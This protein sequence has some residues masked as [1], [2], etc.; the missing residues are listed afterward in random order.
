MTGFI[1]WLGVAAISI[2][3]ASVHA[4][5]WP[6]KPVRFIVPWPAGGL[7]DLIARVYN[8]EVSK[9]IRQPVVVDFKAG[10]GGRIGIT[11]LARAAPD[12]Y[13]I[14]MGNLGPLT[15]YPH[16]YKTLPYDVRKDLVPVTMFAV[17]PQ[18]L[19]VTNKLPAKDV[20][21]LVALAKKEPGKL[22]YASVGIGS[23]QHLALQLVLTKAGAQ[24]VHVPY[25]GTSESLPNLIAGEVHAMIDTLPVL[26][27]QIRAGKIRALAVTTPQRVPQLPDVPTLTEAGY[28]EVDAVSWYA[29]MVPTG[30][31]EAIIS[32][33]YAEYTAA[34]Q[35]PAVKKFLL[36]QGLIYL[37][38]TREQF[39]ARIQAESE[40]WGRIVQ[41]QK[42]S[43]D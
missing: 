4:Q 26:L 24:M 40:R 15:I 32:R 33:L 42:I 25:K 7:N 30:T 6:A 2:L 37:P 8:D 9:A 18:V 43:L 19:V 20:G 35:T 31:P 11:E 3:A 10:A 27:T 5:D 21:E 39:A 16:L 13:T 23:L 17:S 36:E 41:D 12:G 1:R 29:V 14:G 34:A 38:N 28:P 22:N